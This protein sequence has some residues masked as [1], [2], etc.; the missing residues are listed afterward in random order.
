MES[1]SAIS[2]KA[3]N[4][5]EFPV[6]Y[7]S[8]PL[9]NHSIYNVHMPVPNPNPSLPLSMPFGNHKFVFKSYE[10]VSVPQIAFY[11]VPLIYISVFV[12]VPLFLWLIM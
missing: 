9:P 10:S 3:E 7:S 8:M 12:P 2:I 11:P 4:W 1:S 6:L 5:V